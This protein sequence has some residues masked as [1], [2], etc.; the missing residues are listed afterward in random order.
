MT[1]AEMIW[2]FSG[3]TKRLFW[4]VMLMVFTD[5]NDDCMF[6]LRKYFPFGWWIVGSW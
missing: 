4:R 1:C 3:V 6:V 2:K 5:G